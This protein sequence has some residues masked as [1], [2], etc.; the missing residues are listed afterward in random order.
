[1]ESESVRPFSSRTRVALAIARGIAAARGDR[2]LS[3]THIAAGIFRE[4]ANPALAAL[5]HA[6]MPEERIRRYASELER[7]L[8][9][10]PG[11]IP[12]RQVTIDISPGEE[13]ITR[14][15]EIEMKRRGDPYLGTEHFLLAMLRSDSSL[16]KRFGEFG[17]T[18]D[19]Y[20]ESVSAAL[21]GDPPPNE[22][23]PA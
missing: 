13:Q 1:M 9:K 4:G 5:W 10:P 8:G 17:I 21:R 15:A 23:R 7:S 22:P 20:D 3:A 14:S 16:S 11:H 19:R 2:D 6:G 18:V 12:P